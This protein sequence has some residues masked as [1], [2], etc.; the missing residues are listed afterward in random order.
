MTRIARIPRAWAPRP[1]KREVGAAKAGARS[2]PLATAIWAATP[3]G[4]G[5]LRD[6]AQDRLAVDDAHHLAVLDGAHGLI[7]RGDQWNGV[8]HGRLDRQL[9][10]F[11]RLARPGVAHDPAEREH[12]GARDVADEVLDV[13]V[14]RRAHELLRRAELDDRAVAHDRD[15]VAQP[16]RL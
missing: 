15:A 13:L 2:L 8:L 10:A 5:F 6:G 9:R 14:G 4:V 7:R 12:V 11:V 3:G 1:R 16:K